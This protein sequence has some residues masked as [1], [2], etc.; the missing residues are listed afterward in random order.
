MVL[1]IARTCCS[2]LPLLPGLRSLAVLAG[3]GSAMP[4]PSSPLGRRCPETS[5]WCGCRMVPPPTGR[6]ML[7]Q[8]YPPVQE[9][10]MAG[11]A[12]QQQSYI[13]RCNDR[14]ADVHSH[15]CQSRCHLT[16]R[17]P[18]GSQGGCHQPT[19]QAGGNSQISTIE[20]LGSD[21]ML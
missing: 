8:M 1:V 13:A 2:N 14:L 18:G 11:P 5:P 4:G 20:A 21:A 17:P 3:E 9:L 12:V 19:C 10:Q 7:P 16:A 6:Q 15:L